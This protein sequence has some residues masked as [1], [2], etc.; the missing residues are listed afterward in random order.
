MD[1]RRELCEWVKRLN[2]PDGYYS[3]LRNIVDP[4]EVKFNNVKSHDCYVF[5]ETL[6]PIAFG[7]LPDDVLKPLIEISQFF[8]NL[9]SRTLREDVVE[10]MH[11]SIA[12]TLYKL[13]TTFPSGFF[14]VMEHLPVHLEEE[15]LLGGPVQY[16]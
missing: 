3:N 1:K 4:N 6:L 12:I 10:K 16:R 13:V 11:Q 5:M 8:S 7:V 14:N 2:I 9:C 15:A